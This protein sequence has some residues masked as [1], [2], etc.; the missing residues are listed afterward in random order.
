MQKANVFFL[1][2]IF[3]LSA[4]PAKAQQVADTLYSP[5]ISNPIYSAGNGSIVLI[6]EAH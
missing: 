4:P 6:D 1:V 5:D 2:S 3:F